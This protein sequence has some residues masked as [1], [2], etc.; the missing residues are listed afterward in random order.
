MEREPVVNADRIREEM[1][2]M[3]LKPGKVAELIGVS[4]E[5]LY[6]SLNEEN[7]RVSA[8][9]V[10]KLAMLFGCSMEYLLS[11]TDKRSPVTLNLSDLLEK[12]V[13][14]AKTL[15]VVRQ[16]DLL[17]MAETYSAAGEEMTRM[18]FQDVRDTIAKVA[19]ETGRGEELDQLLNLLE[20]A[21][22]ERLALSV[23]ALLPEE[24]G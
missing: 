11:L 3:G 9:M 12:I 17:L 21:E 18:V 5:T 7:R 20:T 4:Y 22:K 14:T 13:Q 15:P 10:A 6:K 1:K 24:S 16:R 8:E 19:D 2:R 23:V